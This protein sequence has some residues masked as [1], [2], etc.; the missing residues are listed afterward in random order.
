LDIGLHILQDGLNY[1]EIKKIALEAE[2]AE[3]DSFWLLDHLHASPK[4][5]EQQMLECWVVLSALAVETRRIRLGMLVQNVNNRNPALVAK[6]TTTLDQISEGRLEFGIG[7]G[8][9]NRSQRQNSLGYESE[10]NAYDIPFPMSA[11]KRIDKLEEG[12]E[13]MKIM[14]TQDISTFKGKYYNIKNAICQPKTVQKPYPPIW[15]GGG[16][17]NRMLKVVAKHA[18]GWNI[19]GASTVDDYN[20]SLKLLRI[21][22][23]KI[24]RK[25]DD[26]KISMRVT[27][28]IEDCEKNLIKFKSIG[29]NLAMFRPPRGKEIEYLRTLKFNHFK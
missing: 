5:D 1:K 17:G 12:L 20:K 18:D 8:G 3:L 7:A 26:I 11:A 13:L 21:A 27:G 10:F 15:I 23:N 2:R 6:M 24:G 4:P 19:M 16:C 25:A 28:S 14:W 22:C 9:T 29:L